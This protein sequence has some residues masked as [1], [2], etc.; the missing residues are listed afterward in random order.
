MNA[1]TKTNF[2]ILDTRILVY[3]IMRTKKWMTK[4]NLYAF[5]FNMYEQ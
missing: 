3:I 2:L 4:R 5:D 1:L